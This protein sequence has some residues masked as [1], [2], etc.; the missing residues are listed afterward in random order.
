MPMAIGLTW[1]KCWGAHRVMVE[2]KKRVFVGLI[3]ISLLILAVLAG[4]SWYLVQKGSKVAWWI[5]LILLSVV[6][7]FLIYAGLGILGLLVSLITGRTPPVLSR[8]QDTVAFALLPLALRVGALLGVEKDRIRASFIEVNNQLFRQKDKRVRPHELLILAPICLQNAD[9]PRKV[10][11]DIGQCRKCGR[12]SVGG[13][14]ELADKYGVNLA[15]ATGGTKARQLIRDLNPQVVIAIACERDLVSGLQDARQITV[16]GITNQRPHG[17]C[18][19]T[20]VDLEKVEEALKAS[21]L[22]TAD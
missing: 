7:G 16:G 18:F 3:S 6:M 12:C 20:Q 10:T 4:T 9:C 22:D 13:L 17:P 15:V 1:G 21:L 19:N 11:N 14:L 8:A 5:L 2:E